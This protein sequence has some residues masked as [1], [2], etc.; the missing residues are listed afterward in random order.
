MADQTPFR[1]P[2]AIT[3]RDIRVGFLAGIVGGGLCL[4][5]L[6]ALLTCPHFLY[7]VL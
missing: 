6:M 2:K 7:Q 5:G 3:E 4:G 1:G